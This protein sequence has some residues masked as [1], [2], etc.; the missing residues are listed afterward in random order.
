[1][2]KPW[3]RRLESEDPVDHR[4]RSRLQPEQRMGWPARPGLGSAAVERSLPA[5]ASGRRL[6]NTEEDWRRESSCLGILVSLDTLHK[7]SS[8]LYL[9]C[10]HSFSSLCALFTGVEF[11]ESNYKDLF[12][13]S[14]FCPL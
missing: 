2:L 12:T 10:L 7:F 1:V 9:V 3:L 5:P 14:F 11:R 6:Q 4:L 13:N 8:F